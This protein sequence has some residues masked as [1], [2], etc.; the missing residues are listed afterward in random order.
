MKER[1]A[2]N[3]RSVQSVNTSVYRKSVLLIALQILLGAGAVF[4]GLGLVISPSGELLHMPLELLD[5][6]PFSDYLIPGLLLT[7]MLGAAPLIVA[8][9][10]IRRWSCRAAER[11]NIY[12]DTHW[13]WTFSLYIGFALVI[14]IS[15]QVYFL[16]AVHLVHLIYWAL[17]FAIQI[18]TLLPGTRTKYSKPA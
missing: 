4:G 8:S 2:M 10:L 11:L 1:I 6:S 3:E 13:S 12:K 5:K 9:A 16:Q 14:W 18:V 15:V 17:G 7:L